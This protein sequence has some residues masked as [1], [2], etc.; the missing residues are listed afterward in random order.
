MEKYKALIAD[1]AGEKII[2]TSNVKL[3]Q[4]PRQV[5]G[6]GLSDDDFFHLTCHIDAS[7]ME[8]IEKEEFVELDKLLPK[9]KRKRTEDNRLEWIQSEGGTF[10]A[11]V[12]DR[13][14]RI[15]GF[16][17]WE[18][19]FRV[20]ATIYCSANPDRSREIWQYVSVINTAAS[21]FIWENV[22]EYDIT[23]RHFMAFNPSHSWAVTYNQMW[24]ICMR[25]PLP[26]KFNNQGQRF[27]GGGRSSSGFSNNKQWSKQQPQKRKKPDYC[28]NFNKGLV[29]KYGKKC[30][31]VERCSY[32]DSP[33]HGVNACT[34]LEEKTDKKAGDRS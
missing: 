24:N 9:D 8:K 18:Q 31:F 13:M 33:T 26:A 4:H 19:A 32:C 15:N 3:G 29:C 28:W 11:P 2:Q 21:S 30:R 22:Y 20:Y 25:D 1:P 10:L 34:K 7:L 14:N 27:G 17:K 12:N 6:D 16:Q 5:V 23:F